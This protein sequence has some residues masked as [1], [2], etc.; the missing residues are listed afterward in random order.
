MHE[1][2]SVIYNTVDYFQSPHIVLSDCILGMASSA[3]VTLSALPV[4]SFFP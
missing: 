2:A 4:V 1:Y 3:R